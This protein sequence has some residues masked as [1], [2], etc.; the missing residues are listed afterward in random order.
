MTV[1]DT[2]AGIS[3]MP[4]VEG[5]PVRPCNLSVR[6]VGGMPLRVLGKQCVSVQIGG[7]TVSHEMFLIEYVTEIIIGLDLLRYV[8]AKVD[9][10]RGK[11]IVGSQVHEL[12]ETSA[13]PCQRCEEIGRSGVFNSM[14]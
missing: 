2:A 5:M 1:I 14:C 3:I 9:F 13:C 12:R 4:Q 10:A 8:G 7:V 6:A 11:L